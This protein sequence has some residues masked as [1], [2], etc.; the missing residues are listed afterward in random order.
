MNPRNSF[1]FFTLLICV[2]AAAQEFPSFRAHD[3]NPNAGT[4]LAIAVADINGDAEPDI[5]GVSDKDVAWYENPSWER[6]LIAGT[7]RG[8]NVCVAAH[9]LDG[10]GLPELALGADWQFNNTDSGGSLHLL[11]RN[12]KS[13]KEVWKVADIFTEPSIHRIRWADTD[14]DGR[15]ELIVAPLKGRGSRPPNFKEAGARLLC[16]MPPA[17]PMTDAWEPEIIS[18]ALRVVHN[19]WPVDWDGDGRDEI[20]AASLE[21]VTHFERNT[22][23]LWKTGT[24]LVPGNGAPWPQ[25]GAGEIKIGWLGKDL[26]VMG[27][28]EPWHANQAVVYT[29]DS[30]AALK[31]EDT[32]VRVVVD[33]ALAGGHAVGF[34]DFDGDGMDEFL[35]GFRDPA[36]PNQRPGLNIYD[37]QIANHRLQTVRPVK[38]V[39]D[40]GGMATED[41]VAHDMNGD[42]RPDIVAFGRATKNIKYYENLGNLP[43][44]RLA[45]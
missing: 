27:T 25:S 33:D 24:V 30:L 17:N 36:G 22:E 6:H 8:S 44:V 7:I 43:A 12:E 35:V 15:A 9:D 40:D 26:P 45:E 4:G 3:I 34:A 41:A 5:I 21:G 42:G 19:I 23:A 20:L 10:D 32:W 1:V 28:I 2:Q 18:T 14:G 39:I 38:H 16:F 11:Q 31:G 29:P 13:G 37:L